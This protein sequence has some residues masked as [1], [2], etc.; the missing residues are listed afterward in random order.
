[1]DLTNLPPETQQMLMRMLEQYQNGTLNQPEGAKRS[2]TPGPLKDLRD[3]G[4][5][6]KRLHRPSFFF[7]VTDSYTTPTEY[8]KVK[9][10]QNGTDTLVLT[11]AAEEA[12]GPEW[13]DTPSGKP[14]DPA[15]RLKAEMMALSPEDQELVRTAMRQARLDKIQRTM[16]ELSPAE[17]EGLLASD[18]AEPAK[19]GP[20]RPRKTDGD[21]P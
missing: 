14:L 1:M 13:G 12:L 17:I 2:P 5:P 15:E 8:P 19:R 6:Q 3:P 20:G 21:R 9:W 10:H 4:D 11:R 16:G 18:A 7:Q